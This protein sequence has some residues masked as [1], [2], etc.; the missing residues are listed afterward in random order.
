VPVAAVLLF[1]AGVCFI[2]WNSN[3]QSLLQLSAPDHLR[4]RVMSLFLFSFAGLG[5]LGALAAG[6]LANTGGTQLAFVV[7]GAAGIS[8]AALG[9][10]KSPFREPTPRPGPARLDPGVVHRPE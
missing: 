1:V 2:L 7:A 3:T 8:M 9:W 5:P 4:G 10:W 6:W